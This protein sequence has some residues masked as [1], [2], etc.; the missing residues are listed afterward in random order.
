MESL[1]SHPSLSLRELRRTLGLTQQ[2]MAR[3]LN[4]GQE[5]VSRIENRSDLRLSTL[6]GYARALGGSLQLLCAF[7]DRAALRMRA[8]LS[9]TAAAEPKGSRR[10]RL[11]GR[12]TRHA[13]AIVALCGRYGVRRLA[14]FG[15]VL[16]EDFDPAASDLDF[17]VE[18]APPAE[19][20]AAHQYFDFKAE[21]EAL[22]GHAVDLVE[23]HALPEGTLKRIIEE[24][25][26]P[27]YAEAA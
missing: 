7:K 5:E 6:Q 24:S 12:I 26:V 19:R 9:E 11:P 16:R 2:E 17:A 25:Q 8:G 10:P 22:L 3:R 21:L 4:K 23:L 13:A 15:S 1:P 27:L 14:I 18:F 20:S